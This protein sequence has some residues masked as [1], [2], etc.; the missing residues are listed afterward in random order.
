MNKYQ[1]IYTAWIN[2]QGFSLDEFLLL[3]LHAYVI[4]NSPACARWYFGCHL[5]LTLKFIW[6]FHYLVFA[7]FFIHTIIF[8]FF[9]RRRRSIKTS[10][11]LRSS[12]KKSN[13]LR[14]SIKTSNQLRLFNQS[15]QAVAVTND[16]LELSPPIQIRSVVVE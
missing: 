2:V 13:Q 10:N 12:I 5:L 15:V 1:Y 9:S 3:S 8:W 16:C 11:Q 4:K 14:S 6:K 7:Q